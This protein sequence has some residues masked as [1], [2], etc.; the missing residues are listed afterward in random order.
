[1]RSAPRNGTEILAYHKQGKNFHS[2]KSYEAP[3]WGMRWHKEYS[4]NDSDYLG[5]IDMPALEKLTHG[6]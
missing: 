3:N 2:V 6:E 4:Q 1:M 5:W